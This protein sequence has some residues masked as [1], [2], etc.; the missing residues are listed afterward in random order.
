VRER[1]E[2]LGGDSSREEG[3]MRSEGKRVVKRIV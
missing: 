2:E 3:R 1:K